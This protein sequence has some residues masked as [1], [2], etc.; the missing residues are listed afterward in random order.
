MQDSTL[1]TEPHFHNRHSW[2]NRTVVGIILA[3]FLSDVS[4]E[5][6]TAVLPLFLAT[7]GFGPAALG[8]IEGFADFLVSLSKLG[9]G[10][11]GHHVHYKRPWASLGY[12]VTTVST[13]ALG[14]VGNLTAFV[15]LRSAAWAGRGFRS[16]LRDYLLADSVEKTHFGRAYGLERAGDMLGAVVGPLLAA[17]LLWAGVEFRT[18]ILW[19][20]IPG[21][22]AAGSFFFLTKE[23]EPFPDAA[24]KTGDLSSL[25]K[26]AFPKEFWL[27]LIGVFLF[28]LG[29]FSRTFVVW[30]S[31]RAVGEDGHM[32]TG[33]LSLAVLLY[34]MHNLVS[35]AAAYP[36]GHVGD[37][38]AKLPV[39]II[40]YGLGVGT[41]LLLAFYSG[42]LVWLVVAIVLSGVYIAIEETLE[43]AV[44]AELLPRERRSLGFGIL[45]CGNAVGDMV[46]S[47]YVGLL[48]EAG[49]TTLAFGIA[50]SLGAVGVGWMLW[51]MRRRG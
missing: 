39:L 20:I 37:Q 26:P 45:A 23:R 41:N 22:L 11:V 48:L 40:G 18:I 36:V 51:L 28:G 43:K 14:L 31:A 17:L 8:M 24:V 42:Q 5:M 19:T 46:S 16:P 29:D 34:M 6:A 13:A 2:V 49:Y 7:V 15:S 10:V 4:H 27:F 3:T 9:G 33:T 35:A 21:L 30:L 32:A 47:L 38:R 44:A 12:L 25:T 50:A 1:P